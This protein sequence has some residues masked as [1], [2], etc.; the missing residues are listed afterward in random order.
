MNQ[1]PHF[2]KRQTGDMPVIIV[3]VGT[4]IMVMILVALFLVVIPNREVRS[5]LNQHVGKLEMSLAEK[6]S[7]LH[8]LPRSREEMKQIAKDN[9]TLEQELTLNEDVLEKSLT[10]TFR[11]NGF[12]VADY[13]L[14]SS[15]A[16]DDRYWV[17]N[18]IDITVTGKRDQLISTIK[19]WRSEVPTQVRLIEADIKPID[20][21]GMIRVVF[22][23]TI[24]SLIPRQDIIQEHQED[25]KT[26]KLPK[27]G[28]FEG[29]KERILRQKIEQLEN[30]I[31]SYRDTTIEV[32]TLRRD[33]KRLL[34]IL[35]RKADYTGK[36]EREF[37]MLENQLKSINAQ[38]KGNDSI[39]I[40]IKV[41]E[42]DIQDPE[43]V[44]DQ[45]RSQR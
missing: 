3:A 45:R 22:L 38:T 1:H 10:K 41:K 36:H 30:E 17:S 37:N 32:S 12:E 21:P 15:H 25:L 33:R 20:E 29:T 31:Q 23:M 44:E 9:A 8:D 7:M 35:S 42:A 13:F 28:F 39:R 6:K 26:M 24:N 11:D 4:A 40:I 43:S 16:G 34:A 27:I 19:K 5:T 2:R 14:G 18:P